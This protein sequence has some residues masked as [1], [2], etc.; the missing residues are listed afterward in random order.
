[1][2]LALLTALVLTAPAEPARDKL[3]LGLQY[4]WWG[5]DVQFVGT[6]PSEA[7]NS[8]VGPIPTGA[9]LD[10]Q[11]FPAAYFVD[12]RGADVGVALRVDMA[13]DYKLRVGNETWPAS[14]VQLRT[15]LLFRLPTRYAEPSIHL[16]LHVF[17]STT[18]T[19]G[20]LGT[21]RP[22]FPNVSFQ[23][24]RLALGVRLLEFWRIT[25][26]VLGGA[27]WLLGTGELQSAAFFPGAKGSAFDA[28]VGLAFRT[29]AWLDVRVGVDVTVHTVQLASGKAMTDALYGMSLG[30]VF[31]GV[32]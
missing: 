17:E 9:T 20:S 25:F 5:R 1:M 7:D 27:T 3:R 22:R 30:V 18:G 23:G 32:P 8:A 26:D 28:S 6:S 12:D 19:L 15:G 29:W 4:R 11:W 13:P 31:K 16:G 24:P 14:S 21:P 10:V 2:T